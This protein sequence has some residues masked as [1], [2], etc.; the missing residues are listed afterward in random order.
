MH[1][2]MSIAL[3]MHTTTAKANVLANLRSTLDATIETEALFMSM[4]SKYR[5]HHN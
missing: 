4:Y 2:G 3:P 1:I 5:T